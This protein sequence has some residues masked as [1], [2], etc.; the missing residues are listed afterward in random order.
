[1]QALSE[2]DL[3]MCEI[4][5]VICDPSYQDI[6]SLASVIFLIVAIGCCAVVWY[7]IED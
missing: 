4:Y 5:P 2:S 3:A 7:L 1:M 6:G